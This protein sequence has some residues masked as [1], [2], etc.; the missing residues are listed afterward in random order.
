MGGSE[1][2]RL[3]LLLPHSQLELDPKYANQT[4][5]LC[6]DFNGLPAFNE[7][8]AHSECHLGEGAV[9]DCQPAKGHSPM[10]AGRGGVGTGHRAGR[11]HKGCALHGGRS[12]PRAHQALGRS[13]SLLAWTQEVGAHTLS[14]GSPQSHHTPAFFPADAR[15]TPIQFG[16]L[17]KLDGPTEQCPDPLPLPASNCTDEVSFP[18]APSFWAGSASRGE[19]LAPGQG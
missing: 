7:F 8:Y 5:G 6:G 1:V 18:P 11:G 14:P 10:E 3:E 4:C 19:P 9:T 15:L 17:Q 13:G 2:L 16:N 12:T